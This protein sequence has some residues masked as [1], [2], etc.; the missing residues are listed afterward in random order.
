MIMI[1]YNIAVLLVIMGGLHSVTGQVYVASSSEI[2][3]F[4]EA[5]QENIEALNKKSSSL[6]NIKTNQLVFQ[7]PIGAFDFEKDLMEEHFNENYMETE[8]YPKATFDGTIMEGVDFSK[9]GTYK[10]QV[11]GK[12]T[13]HGVTKE[14][15]I[16]GEITVKEGAIS[17]KSQFTVKL[18]EHNVAIPK[19][20][21]LKIAEE[22]L[23]TIKAAYSPYK[24][25]E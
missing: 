5:P 1:K 22:V 10:A 25:K 18:E 2:S 21:V 8:K 4:S 20:V 16:D 12:L 11:S 7:I 17:L 13:I 19:V 9:D 6:L 3:F 24:K 23:V 14:R 15:R